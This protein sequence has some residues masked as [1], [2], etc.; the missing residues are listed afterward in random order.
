MEKRFCDNC[1]SKPD[2]KAIELEDVIYTYKRKRKYICSE[3]GH[4]SYRRGLRPT[5]ESVY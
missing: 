1:L 2:H 5:A 3:C 4:E